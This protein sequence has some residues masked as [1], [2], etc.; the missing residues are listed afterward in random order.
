MHSD[1]ENT[2]LNALRYVFGDNVVI[3]LCGAHIGR[4]LSTKASTFKEAH[5]LSLWCRGVLHLPFYQK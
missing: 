4:N 2:I 1:E 5:H 3:F